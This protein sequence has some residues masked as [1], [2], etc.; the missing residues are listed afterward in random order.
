MKKAL[1]SG[2][3]GQD[4]SYLSE[5]LLEKGY[6]VYGV[7][8][9]VAIENVNSRYSRIKHIK[10]DLKLYSGD[11]RDYARMFEIINEVKPDELYHLAAQSFV[12]VSFKDEQTILQGNIGG[13]V[14]ILNILRKVKPNCKFYHAASSEMFGQVLETPQTEKTPFNPR[15]P[16]G[17]GKCTCFQW[18]RL[19]REAYNMF[20]CNGI[21]F[22]HESERRGFEFVTRKITRAVAAIKLGKQNELR[23][24]NLEA[25][26]DWGHAKDYVYAMFLMLQQSKPDDYVVATGTTRS[27]KDFLS[28]AFEYLDLNWKDYVKI[29]PEFFRPADVNVLVG[30]ASKARKVLKWAPK[31]SFNE[32]VERMVNHDLED[33]K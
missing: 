5:L 20:C 14:N 22:N 7:E 1:V 17:I 21:L 25:R 18:T 23:L 28:A 30:D 12:G 9:R 6:E 32:L 24:G 4:G 16:Y 31:V 10:N 2:V 27:I 19:Y 33:L 3:C 11:I 26:R 15:S 13:T 29:D 8:R